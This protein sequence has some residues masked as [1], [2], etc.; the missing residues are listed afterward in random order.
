MGLNI[1]VIVKIQT[2]NMWDSYPNSDLFLITT[3][4]YV[5][6]DGALVMGRGIAYQ[7]KSRY[8]TIPYQAGKWLRDN[9]LANN[10]YGILTEPFDSHIGLFQVKI[11]YADSA[12]LDLIELSAN[13]LSEYIRETELTSVNLN[14]PGIGYGHL[15]E[16]D[17]Q[18]ILEKHF[19]NL[20]VTIWKY[21]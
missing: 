4:S 21:D 16:S 2:G 15:I 13:M 3:N 6:K 20:P 19:E 8:P 1:G 12:R 11:H 9:K 17:V 5:R 18:P 10:T 14:Y 7:A